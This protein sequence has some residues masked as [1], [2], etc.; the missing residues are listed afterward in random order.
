MEGILIASLGRRNEQFRE[1]TALL[2]SPRS[3]RG[4]ILDSL[5]IWLRAKIHSKVVSAAGERVRAPVFALSLFRRRS[6]RKWERSR[7]SHLPAVGGAP[8][9]EAIIE[10]AF[11]LFARRR[12]VRAAGNI[13]P[14][15]LAPIAYTRRWKSVAPLS[16]TRRVANW[17]ALQWQFS[18]LLSKF[19]FWF[20]AGAAF[21]QRMGA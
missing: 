14:L 9:F 17:A 20:R 19:P 1:K 6:G 11:C 3:S 18:G 5:L 10:F 13:L 21:R 2:C 15:S 7:Q 4:A 8:V 16:R 12:S